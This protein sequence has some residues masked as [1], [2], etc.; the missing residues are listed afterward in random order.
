M[1]AARRDQG[2]AAGKIIGPRHPDMPV[3]SRPDPEFMLYLV[4]F[5]I[6]VGI[7]PQKCRRFRGEVCFVAWRRQRK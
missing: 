1:P 7:W 2:T 4:A 3:S 6:D 5:V